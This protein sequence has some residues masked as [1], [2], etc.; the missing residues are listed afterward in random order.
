MQ[1]VDASSVRLEAGP[2]SDTLH[3]IR[4]S[5]DHITKLEAEASPAVKA[6]LRPPPPVA[7]ANPSLGAS[8]SSASSPRTSH[9]V[10][11][12]H[13]YECSTHAPLM[14]RRRAVAAPVNSATAIPFE[15]DLFAG[16]FLW[17]HAMPSG[18]ANPHAKYFEDKRRLWEVRIQGRFKALPKGRLQCGAML[19][20]TDFHVAPGVGLKTMLATGRKLV[21]KFVGDGCHVTLGARGAESKRPGAELGHAVGDLRGVD[22][23]I[24]IPEGETPPPIEHDLD[25]YG[26]QRRNMS[27]AE[28]AAYVKGITNSISVTT[29]YTFAFWG[30]ARF[31]NLLDWKYLFLPFGVG[32]PMEPSY[33]THCVMYALDDSGDRAGSDEQHLESRKQY[34][35]DILFFSSKALPLDDS[36]LDTYEGFRETFGAARD[37]P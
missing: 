3:R 35:V 19:Q 2:S 11:R 6:A 33:P 28:W 12:L 25:A 20:E 24:A 37:I 10:D 8:L 30:M 17:L 21:N 18:E 27:A 23:L 4:L 9:Q 32:I 15:N 34:A 13:I 36:V 14:P 31:A 1:E 5:V 16:Q 29:T 7:P 22:Q 26:C